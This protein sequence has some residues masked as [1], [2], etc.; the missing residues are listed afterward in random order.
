MIPKC[1]NLVQRMTLGYTRRDMVWGG[2]KK[3]KVK[4]TELLSPFCI[5]DRDSLSLARWR[6]QSSAWDIELCE[7]LLVW[8]LYILRTVSIQTHATHA[9]H[10]TQALALRALREK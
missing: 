3:S 6:N 5:L 1:S 7:C 9:S 8:I 2:V 4:V 10:A